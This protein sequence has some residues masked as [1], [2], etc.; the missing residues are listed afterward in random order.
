MMDYLVVI[1]GGRQKKIEIIMVILE[2]I[3]VG[4]N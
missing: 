2:N 4:E 1:H 3:D